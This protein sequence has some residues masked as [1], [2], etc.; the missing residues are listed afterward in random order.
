MALTP[1]EKTVYVGAPWVFGVVLTLSGIVATLSN[2]VSTVPRTEQVIATS[3]LHG[4]A[5]ICSGLICTSLFCLCSIVIKN[6]ETKEQKP[7]GK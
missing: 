2:I 5:L 3:Q 6:M 7:Q 1:L 4:I